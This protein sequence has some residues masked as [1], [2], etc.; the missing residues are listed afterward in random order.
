ME[1]ISET[2]EEENVLIGLGNMGGIGEKLV[3]YW[4]NIGRPHDF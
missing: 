3:K 2:L 1:E 4:E